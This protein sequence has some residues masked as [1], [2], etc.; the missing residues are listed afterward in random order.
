MKARPALAAA[1]V[2]IAIGGCG[3]KD[4][5]P[6]AV[7]RTSITAKV[8]APAKTEITNADLRHVKAPTAS[9]AFLEYWS[10]LQWQEWI[11]AVDRYSAGLRRVVGTSRILEAL[12]H[13][14]SFYRAVKPKIEREATRKGLTTIRY[15]YIDS[16]GT[17]RLSST[18]WRMEDGRWTLVY[19]GL[20]DGALQSWAQTRTQQLTAP[21][22]AKPTAAALK[23]GIEASELQA[24]YLPFLGLKTTPRNGSR[25]RSGTASSAENP[26]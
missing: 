21:D 13:Q 18:I 20:L 2:A 12:Q 5:A 3:S 9:H 23:A 16:A 7:E 1:A 25:R 11:S 4:P 14:A 8:R 22:A 15:S 26:G 19:D 6:E 10:E 17:R 24:R